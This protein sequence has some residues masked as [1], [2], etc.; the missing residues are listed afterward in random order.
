MM[1]FATFMGMRF[2]VCLGQIQRRLLLTFLFTCLPG[3]NAYASTQHTILIVGDSLSA[4][5]GLSR[6]QGW[7][8]LLEQRLQESKIK[9]TVINAS[10]SGETTS[11]GKSRIEGL[12]KKHQPDIAVI[13]LG[14]NDA[15]RG[16]ALNATQENLRQML[17][18]SKQFNAKTLLLGMRIPPN[19]GTHYAEQ[20]FQLY[21]RLAKDENVALVPFFL[22]GVAEKPELFQ[23]D[24]I[25]P[26]AAAH[27]IM[28]G[29]VWPQLKPLLGK[30]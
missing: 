1:G 2:K 28:L 23:A 8:A 14:G 30:K 22:E 16:L 7:V 17:R 26:V 11:G 20:F 13:E 5:Y 3:T 4:E 25:H 10:I 29:N 9:A 21:A 12:L 24:H 27:P 6:G 15:L 19:Y 18:L